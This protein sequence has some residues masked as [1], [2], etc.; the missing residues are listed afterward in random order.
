MKS[1]QLDAV[2]DVDAL[3]GTIAEAITF[4]RERIIGYMGM[5]CMSDELLSSQSKIEVSE[6]L[7]WS[8]KRVELLKACHDALLALSDHGYPQ[9]VVQ[10]ALLDVVKELRERLRTMELSVK[11]FEAYPSIKMVAGDPVKES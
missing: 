3:A 4:E 5:L 1:R 8:N 9:R 7:N 10:Q 2:S 6:A 11:E